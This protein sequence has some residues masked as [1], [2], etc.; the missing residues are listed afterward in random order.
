LRVERR[1]GVKK[2]VDDLH[3][4]IGMLTLPMDVMPISA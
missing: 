1:A 2:M 4:R 3:D